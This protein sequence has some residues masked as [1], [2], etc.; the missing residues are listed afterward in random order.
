VT[1][2][3]RSDL[4]AR[5]NAD[6][7]DVCDLIVRKAGEEQR[8]GSGECLRHRAVAASPSSQSSLSRPSGLPSLSQDNRGP[9]LPKKQPGS[10][11]R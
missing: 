8:D 3:Q 7:M 5:M 1:P 4:Y 10:N 9:G 11:S 2:Q 6:V